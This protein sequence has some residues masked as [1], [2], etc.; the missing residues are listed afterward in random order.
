MFS[1][2]R[3]TAASFFAIVSLTFVSVAITAAAAPAKNLGK[4]VGPNGLAWSVALDC[5]TTEPFADVTISTDGVYLRE[6]DGPWVKLAAQ[7]GTPKTA[8]RAWRVFHPDGRI[9]QFTLLPGPGSDGMSDRTYAYRLQVS[10]SGTTPIEGACDRFPDGARPAR[11][12]NVASNDALVIRS[13]PAITSAPVTT[14]GLG[15]YV[16]KK[17]AP[18]KNNWVPI[19]ASLGSETGEAQIAAGWVNGNFLDRLR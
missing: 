16:W 17:L 14:V 12:V 10:F 8:L 11:V 13:A 7:P 4:V 3:R 19:F 2:F 15:G 1:P 9:G 18:D 5:G 6:A